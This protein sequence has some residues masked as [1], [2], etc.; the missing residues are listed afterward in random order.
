LR[1]RVLVAGYATRHVAQ[2]AHQAGYSV[3]AVDHFGDLDLAWY[4][5]DQILFD[6]LTDLP[7]AIEEMVQCWHFDGMV[8]T[9]GAE[10]LREGPPRWGSCPEKVARFMDK[11]LTAEFFESIGVR[12]PKIFWGSNFPAMAKPRSG[13]G[14]WRN[15]V[16]K[17]EEELATWISA[18]DGAP[19]LL[20]ELVTGS[21]ASVCCLATEG[22]ARAVAVNHQVLRGQSPSPY[23]FAGSITPCQHPHAAAMTTIAQRIAAESGCTGTV[24]IDFV[25]GEEAC[26]IELNPRFQ[27]TLDTVE[28]ATGVNLFSLHCAAC[29]GILPVKMPV[30]QRVAVRKI[31][32]ADRQIEISS[33]IS[34]LSPAVADIPAPG[35]TIEEGHAIVSVYGWGRTRAD[36][37]QRLNKHIHLVQSN[38][39]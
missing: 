38:I 36:A 5:D 25:L 4:T 28:M 7:G 8:V 32:F 19:F 18:G 26:A 31:L 3:C 13:A 35:T 30:P 23:G 9:S 37:C 17:S 33:D 15:A 22:Y 16:V 12:C 1:Q 20:Q 11:V 14:G 27:A 10:L 34:D 24:G 2:S 29:S 6:D 21:P 39:M